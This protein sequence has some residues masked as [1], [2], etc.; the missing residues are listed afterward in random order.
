MIHD[1]ERS[2]RIASRCVSSN[3]PALK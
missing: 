1:I 3:M 2:W